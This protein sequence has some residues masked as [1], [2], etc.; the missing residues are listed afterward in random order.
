MTPPAQPADP[1]SLPLLQKF[2]SDLNAYNAQV[3]TLQDAYKKAVAD[4]QKQEQAYQTQIEAYQKDFTDLQVKRV[5]AV[6]SA[7]SNIQLYKD[8]FGWTFVDKK[9]RASYLRTMYT[10]W[11]AQGIIILLFFG[12]TVFLQ[13]RREVL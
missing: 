5:I 4:W 11:G 8:D 10:T 13:K 7:E 1:N 12:A 6:G 2:L 3:G 9:D